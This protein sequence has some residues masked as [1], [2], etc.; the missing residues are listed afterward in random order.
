MASLH[1]HDSTGAC[2]RP[3]SSTP[4]DTHARGRSEDGFT[5]IELL[6]AAFILIV[7][8]LALVGTFDTSRK[9]TLAS[10]RQTSIAHRAQ[11]EIERLYAVPYSELAMT[12]A[13]A[14][15]T[16]ESNP[17]YYVNSEKTTYRWDPKSEASEPLAISAEKGV[18]AASPTAWSAEHMSGNVYDF[19][20][21]HTD[22]ICEEAKA[23]EEKNCPATSNNYKRVTVVV[24]VTV[25]S[26]THPVPPIRV[27]TLI[28][29]P[30]AVPKG[31]VSNGKQN[32]LES[33]STTC[34]PS[35]E[36]CTNGID[37]GNARIW[38]LHDTPASAGSSTPPT[39]SHVTHATVAPSGPKPDLMDSSSPTGT[40]L[41]YYSTDQGETGYTGGRLLKPD[42]V[43]SGTPTTSDN[44]K[45]ELWVTTPLSANTILKGVGG[46]SIY[47]QTFKEEAASVTMCV[48]VYDVPNS[49]TNL[50]T[51]PPTLLGHAEYTPATWP[52]KPT[53]LSFIFKFLSSGTVTVNKEHRIGLRIWTVNTTTNNIAVLYDTTTY[54]SIVQLNTE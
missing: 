40:T 25:P 4:S 24:T 31:S 37:S 42:T 1:D 33:P 2:A 11:Q 43:C 22:K 13:P 21:W 17:D 14:H 52:Q 20:T 45:G 39:A 50:V 27:S 35:N 26:G 30:S 54:P 9:L 28:A 53:Q 38:F 41:Y 51:S 19:V 46:L 48:G 12:S 49:I 15:S 3:R 47:T 32:P 6:A 18:V 44:T 23:G 8:I 34:G 10:E 29:D 36:P 7:G 16:E 5:L